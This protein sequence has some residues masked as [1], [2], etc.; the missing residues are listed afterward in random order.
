MTAELTERTEP[1]RPDRP[2]DAAVQHA[3]EVAVVAE[4]ATAAEAESLGD[5][6]QWARQVEEARAQ[7]EYY[8]DQFL[9]ARAEIENMSRRQ[10]KEL[11]NAHKFALENFVR[12]LLPVRDSLELGQAAASVPEADVA[13]LRE[14]MELTLK[15]LSDVMSKFGVERL[16]PLGAPFDPAY[17]QAMSLQPRADVPPNTVVAVMQCGYTLN[18]RLTRPALVLVSQAP[19]ANA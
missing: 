7:A 4:S 19:E 3:E 1:S 15:L 12:E 14:G 11:E 9:R 10:A 13:K 5:V 18:G 16:D 17:H 2:A 6:G 8:R